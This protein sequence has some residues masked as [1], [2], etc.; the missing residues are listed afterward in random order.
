MRRRRETNSLSRIPVACALFCSLFVLGMF[1]V[2]HMTA[3]LFAAGAEREA[4]KDGRSSRPD[5]G[6]E[7]GNQFDRMARI[8]F[9]Q[10]FSV[11]YQENYKIVTVHTPWPQAGRELRYI[12][13]QRGTP[14]P[15]GYGDALHLEI[16][17]ERII[18]LS[19]T[20]LPY[21][22]MLGL[23]D[24]IIGHDD[25]KY[26]YTPS[27][28]EMIDEGRIRE[29]GEGSRADVELIMAMAPDLIMT[30][31]TGNEQDAYPK[32]REAGLPVVINA[33]W[34]EHTPLAMA[35]WIK[36]IA[37]FFNREAEAER[38]FST[39]AEQYNELKRRAAGVPDRPTVLIG[40][41]FQGTWWMAGGKSFFASLIEDAGAVY[42]WNDNQDRGAIPLGFEAVYAR[43]ANADFW[44]NTGYWRRRIEALEED[45]RFAEFAP[46]QAGTMYNNNR[47]LN[48][49]GGND[50][51]ESG[52]ANPHLVL[53]DLVAIFHP[54]L[55]PDHEFVYYQKLD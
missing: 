43:G 34:N 26:V 41:P 31:H 4:M 39:I 18:T 42:L 5:A 55:V 3:V 50:F 19:T 45:P 48:G 29:V 15:S 27:V 7:A 10:G 12:L 2:F 11:E 8:R 13:F 20:Y 24:R 14:Q 9:A 44:I 49:F 33:E 30:F 53:A 35:E 32:L 46:Y 17:A 40:A 47:R 22:D 25:F 52:R 36:F 38:I 51:W 28:R 1:P 21:L 37:L 23:T 54:E 6:G 16:P